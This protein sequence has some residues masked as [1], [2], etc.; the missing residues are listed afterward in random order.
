MARNLTEYKLEK[1]NELSYLNSNIFNMNFLPKF[2]SKINF[3]LDISGNKIVC[4]PTLRSIWNS[5]N[6]VNKKD[7]ILYFAVLFKN[8]L[9]KKRFPFFDFIEI[10]QYTKNKTIKKKNVI[11]LNEEIW[12]FKWKNSKKKKKR[13][14]VC[15]CSGFKVKI[16]E[17]S[18]VYPGF[19][20][21]ITS[22]VSINLLGIFQ[23]KISWVDMFL[24]SGDIS[25]KIVVY[26]INNDLSLIQ[27]NRKA[28]HDSPVCALNLILPKKGSQGYIIS[29]G[30]DSLVKLWRLSDTIEPIFQINYFNRKIQN[31]EINFFDFS[32][33]VIYVALDNGFFS[34]VSPGKNSEIQAILNH[35][36]S[37][38][39]LIILES[40]IFSAGDDGDFVL[41]DFLFPLKRNSLTNNPIFLSQLILKK[42][43]KIK[44]NKFFFGNKGT[45]F[46]NKLLR[47]G[48]LNQ[49][50]F[51]VQ[52]ACQSNLLFFF[53]FNY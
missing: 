43:S 42:T 41:G 8:T 36:G 28:H 34:L 40:K 19:S 4:E 25:G 33:P 46:S 23:W 44:Y 27:I 32:F 16:F 35:Q 3:K 20:K 13:G 10:Y 7:D 49:S 5:E 53:F 18:A 9:K 11:F 38:S 51:F 39:N 17:V 15:I 1:M 21:I 26:Y 37:L 47:T 14:V 30:F 29:G 6:Y 24:V 2:F 22:I 48:H 31:I 12:D 52:I 50:K 45:K